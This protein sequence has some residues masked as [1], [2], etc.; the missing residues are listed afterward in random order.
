MFGTLMADSTHAKKIFMLYR[1]VGSRN[2]NIQ[3]TANNVSK[4]IETIFNICDVENCSDV[5]RKH[6]M[7]V[8]Q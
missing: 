6:K 7:I 3:F 2:F 1:T 8:N 5:S 4:L